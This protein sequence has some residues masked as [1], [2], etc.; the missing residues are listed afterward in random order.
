MYCGLAGYALETGW[1]LEWGTFP[2]WP[3]VSSLESGTCLHWPTV[4]LMA[5]PSRW[6]GILHGTAHQL[7]A[8]RLALNDSG[9]H[10]AELELPADELILKG[11]FHYNAHERLD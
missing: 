1:S 6:I 2:H 9:L 11:L 3:T 8:G 7:A 10:W 4:L 5:Q